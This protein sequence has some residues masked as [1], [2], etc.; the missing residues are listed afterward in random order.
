M[1]AICVI[2]AVLFAIAF[3]IASSISRVQTMKQKYLHGAVIMATKIEV[4]ESF[5]QTGC[6]L[7]TT[8]GPLQRPR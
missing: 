3:A 2:L 5:S 7:R 8:L 4:F 1:G 6:L